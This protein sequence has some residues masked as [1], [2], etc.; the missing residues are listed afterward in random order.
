[1]HKADDYRYI[2]L[3]QVKP[4]TV[5]HYLQK[6]SA[7]WLKASEREKALVH[8]SLSLFWSIKDATRHF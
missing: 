2:V 8:I 3:Y 6:C 5:S 1:M 7:F 4:S